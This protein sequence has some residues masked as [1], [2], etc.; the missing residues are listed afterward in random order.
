MRS[1]QEKDAL[2]CADASHSRTRRGAGFP[3]AAGMR[4][5]ACGVSPRRRLVRFAPPRI[6]SHSAAVGIPCSAS[7]GD[8]LRGSGDKRAS[9]KLADAQ[10]PGWPQAIKKAAFGLHG[11]APRPNL[12]HKQMRDH[13]DDRKRHHRTNQKDRAQFEDIERHFRFE[14]NRAHFGHINQLCDR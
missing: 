12:E 8:A 2:P 1:N 3:G 14:N 5:P 13:H 6:A 4:P 9:R 11:S 7:R 10:A